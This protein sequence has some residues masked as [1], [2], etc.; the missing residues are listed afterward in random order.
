MCL[1]AVPQTY[2]SS[3][4]LLLLPVVATDTVVC[5][6]GWVDPASFS[7]SERGHGWGSEVDFEGRTSE[8]HSEEGSGSK[9]SAPTRHS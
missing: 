5:G 2:E 3:H 9:V 8:G 1:P 6:L 4:R 7:P